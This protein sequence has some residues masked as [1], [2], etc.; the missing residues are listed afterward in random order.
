MHNIMLH[1]VCSNVV[2]QKP[3][4]RAKYA[5]F[6]NARD[7]AGAALACVCQLHCASNHSGQNI[8]IIPR[9]TE[10]TFS[11]RHLFPLLSRQEAAPPALCLHLDEQP[12]NS[13]PF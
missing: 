10:S 2:H 8:A 3:S 9:L 6:I 13:H 4:L 1:A 11:S 7:A 5:P 12:L